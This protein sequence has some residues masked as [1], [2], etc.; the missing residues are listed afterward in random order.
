M[1]DRKVWQLNLELLPRNSHRKVNN[2]KEKKKKNEKGVFFRIE[3]ARFKSELREFPMKSLLRF[4]PL[5][6]FDQLVSLRYQLALLQVTLTRY[7]QTVY[8]MFCQL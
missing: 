4:A 6:W 7:S 2:E 1:E 5:G 3:S 8:K